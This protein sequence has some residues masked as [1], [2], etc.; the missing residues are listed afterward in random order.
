MPKITGKSAAG[1]RLRALTGPEKVTEVGKALFV[2]GEMIDAEASRLITE[3]AVSG[4]NH[5]PSLP[6]QPPNED[7]G[8]LRIHI[9]VEQPAPLRVLVV[10][11]SDHAV[12][13]EGG[14]VN[15]VERPYMGPASR[16]KRKEVV[17]LVQAAVNR[18]TRK[19]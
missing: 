1:R 12:P 5:V 15:M 10:S 19:R 9:H 13:L 6:G 3:G 4:K 18:A 7:T 16:A 14:T 17:A 2:A 8:D 11:D